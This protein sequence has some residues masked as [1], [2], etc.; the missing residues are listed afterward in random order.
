MQIS[1]GRMSGGVDI[2]AA[3]L[4]RTGYKV[5]E[6]FKIM[7]YA[8]GIYNKTCCSLEDITMLECVILGFRITY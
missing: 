6:Y 8:A 2:L 4:S 7:G 5:S 3:A 1:N